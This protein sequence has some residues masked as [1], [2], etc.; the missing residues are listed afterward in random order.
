MK[1]EIVFVGIN[2]KIKNIFSKIPLTQLAYACGIITALAGL[3]VLFGWQFDITILKTFGLGGVTM[4]PNAGALFLLSGITLLLLQFAQPIAK[5]LARFFSLLIILVGLLTL[6]QFV[7]TRNFGIDELLYRVTDTTGY[8]SNPSRIAANAALNFVFLGIVLFYLSLQRTR[9]NFFIE[10]CFVAAFSISVVGF[11]SFVF[12]FSDSAGATG[13]SRM[14]VSA[15]ASFL[16]L[17]SGIHF[18]RRKHVP[19][20]TIEQKLFAGLTISFTLILFIIVLSISNIQSMRDAADLVRHTEVVKGEIRNVLSRTIDIETGGRGYLISGDENYYEPFKKASVEMPKILKHLYAFTIDNPAQQS[21]IKKLEPLIKKRIE[22]T[23]ELSVVRKT[24]GLS[25]AVSLLNTGKSKVVSDSIRAITANMLEEEDRQSEIRHAVED[26]RTDEMKTLGLAGFLIQV[27]LLLLIFVFIKRDI[28]GRRKAEESLQKLNEELEE[29]VNERTA[30]LIQSEK[31]YRDIIETSLVGVYSTT[32]Q[33]EIL[34]IN[35]AIVQMMEADS[36]VEYIS[37]S[38]LAVYKNPEDR[39]RLLNQLQV[40]GIVTNFEVEM[41]T[42]KGNIITVLLSAKLQNNILTGMVLD[43]TVRKKAEEKIKKANRV[44]AVLSNINQ[45][46]VR[47][48]DKQTLCNEAC[49]IAVE[50]GKFRMAWIGM[51]DQQTNKVLPAASYGLTEDYLKTINIDLNDEKLSQGPTGRSVK[52]GVH[53]LA[54][55]IAND[56]EMVPWRNEA[57]KLGYIS[58]AAFPIKVFGS[59]IGAV[60]L[61]ANEPFFFDEAEVKLLDELAMDISFAIEFFESETERKREENRKRQQSQILES[62]VK[63]MSLPTILELIVK[64]VEKEDSTSL[65]S[66][67]LLDDEGKHLYSSAA[68][69]LPEFYNQAI[70]GLTIGDGVGSCGAAAYSKKR[71]I[72]KDL[73]THPNWIPY[74]ELAQRANLRSCWS[75]PILDA[76][77]NVLGTFAIYHRQPQAPRNEEIE[78]LTSVVY[79]ASLAITS[80]KA[81]EEIRNMNAEL[82]IRIE[83]RTEQLAE[84]NRNLHQEIEER[85]QVED[86]FKLVV[87]SA[88][89]AIILVD[90]NGIIQLVNSQTENYFGYSRKELLG[91]KIELLVP[92]ASGMNHQNLRSKFISHP[93]ARSM[94]VAGDLFGLRKD[95]TIIPIE[96]GLNPL[97][98]NEETFIL[99]SIIDITERKKA[100]EIIKAAKAEAEQANIAKSEFLSR[101]SHELR[102]PLNSILGFAQ[103][104]DMGELAPSH[105]KGVHQIMKSGKHL[106]D[107]INEVLDISKI[108]AGHLTISPEPVEIYGIIS[109]TV[110][111]VR[112]IAEEN[113]ISLEFD[114]S[115]FKKL[116]VK[117]D[118]QRLK[119]VLLNLI[120]NAVKYNR[121]GGSVKVECKAIDSERLMRISVTDT[122]MGLVQENIEKLFNPFVRIDEERNGVEG[123]GL[124]LTISKRLI[125]AMGGKI[126]V[127]SERGKGSIFW[128][129]LPQSESQKDRHERNGDFIKSETKTANISGTLLYIE[130]NYSNIQLVEQIIETHRPSIRLITDMYG[131]NAV[132]LAIDYKP[133]LILLDLDLPDIYGNKVIKLLQSEPRTVEIPVIILSADAMTKQIEQ[134]MEAGAKNYLTK[135]I[136]VV[137]FLMVVDEELGNR[138]KEGNRQ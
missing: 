103:L 13:Y 134:L 74:R 86:R 118:R 65:C 57:I 87:E 114:P 107:L 79:L 4:K 34:Y 81:E 35:D 33:G 106:L 135:P 18:T 76:K 56:P 123:T 6:A 91:K 14:P 131:K 68:P 112:H 66:I 138:Q 108:E 52:S 59:T 5:W 30:E 71:V 100:D 61:Y 44:Y 115:I 37:S 28:T 136:D 46:I 38:I 130:D 102:T 9:L 26:S 78:L 89:N 53:Y 49:R 77:G 39:N 137:Q 73:L 127:E 63:G 19:G 41:I 27:F 117:A 116:F 36:A 24:K 21:A 99:T 45:A 48:K 11:L 15:A 101:M 31:K 80:K 126:G 64:S 109:E 69:S 128:V 42:K 8:I 1:Y 104:M 119:Q 12:G 83:E 51:I 111:I 82:E 125:E 7:F 17:C 20:I 3:V 40:N 98:I 50:D 132:Q 72:A 121:V 23:E 70:D 96:V 120:N 58:S 92:N 85:K 16:I 25:E 133:D 62:I 55:D 32:L 113:Q 29:K 84:T 110:D 93:T 60:N 10:F 67:L 97:R 105:K 129:E 122:G 54:N 90:S 75:E 22:I 43:I 2:M 124:G 94:G 95:G 88:P 47:L